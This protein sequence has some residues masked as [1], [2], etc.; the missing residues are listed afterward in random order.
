MA[1]LTPKGETANADAPPPPPP[2]VMPAWKPL[3]GGGHPTLF[4]WRLPM[5]GADGV[6]PGCPWWC[7]GRKTARGDTIPPRAVV[8]SLWAADPALVALVAAVVGTPEQRHDYANG[9][10]LAKLQAER[11]AKNKSNADEIRLAGRWGTGRAQSVD[12]VALPAVS[13]SRA[14]LDRIQEA[15]AAMALAAAALHARPG[16]D[17]AKLARMPRT[18]FVLSRF[19]LLSPDQE[20]T[21]ADI[22]PEECGT[23]GQVRPRLDRGASIEDRERAGADAFGADPWDEAGAA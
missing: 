5:E 10:R 19:R 22:V 17:A 8:L 11:M 2:Q 16:D 20:R 13:L 14:D 9:R 7:E 15:E 21:L 6:I 18:W 1:R 4:G 23:Y 12:S 3:R